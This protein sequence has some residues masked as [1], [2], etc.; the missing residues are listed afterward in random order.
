MRVH[1]AEGERLVDLRE[2]FWRA[3]LRARHLVGQVVLDQ[4]RKLTLHEG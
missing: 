1:E 4:Q 2:R 3:V